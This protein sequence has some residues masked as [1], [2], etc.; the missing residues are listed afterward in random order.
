MATRLSL[1][2]I[3]VLH[4]AR[5]DQQ[6]IYR[7]SPVVPLACQASLPEYMLC[8]EIHAEASMTL[9]STAEASMRESVLQAAREDISYLADI[10]AQLNMLDPSQADDLQALRGIQA[11]KY[12]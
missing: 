6:C 1:P 5:E 12:S 9:N 3:A 10:E 11:C 7:W 8:P 2:L 4:A